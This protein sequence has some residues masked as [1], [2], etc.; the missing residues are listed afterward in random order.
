MTQ[1]VLDFDRHVVRQ[2]RELLVQRVHD[3]NRVPNAIKKV[4]IAKG[5]MLRTSRHLLANI[6]QNDMPLHDAETALI[7]RH[8]GTMAAEV[9]TATAGFSVAHDALVVRSYDQLRIALQGG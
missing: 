2:V 5:D 9:L 7:H 8:N 3:W 1:K 4:R 6:L